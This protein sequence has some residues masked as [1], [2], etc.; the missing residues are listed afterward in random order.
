[1]LMVLGLLELKS[2]NIC[3]NEQ[4][5][6]YYCRDIKVWIEYSILYNSM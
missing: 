6:A 5:G 3:E 2:I 4:E 1:M